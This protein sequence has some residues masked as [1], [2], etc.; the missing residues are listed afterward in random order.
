M[1]AF[2]LRHATKRVGAICHSREGGNRVKNSLSRQR[3]DTNLY[4]T[5]LCNAIHRPY[6]PLRGNDKNYFV[7]FVKFIFILMPFQNHL[8]SKL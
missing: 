2:L 7:I 3:R 8:R 4:L 1:R 5:L 6:S